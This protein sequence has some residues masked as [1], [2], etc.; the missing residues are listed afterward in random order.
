MVGY[1]AATDVVRLRCCDKRRWSVTLLLQTSLVGYAAAK[2]RLK[3]C[4][5]T[6]TTHVQYIYNTTK[7]L[8]TYMFAEAKHCTGY[9]ILVKLC[10]QAG[11]SVVS[12]NSLSRFAT[13]S[14][15]TNK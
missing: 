10:L 3:L 8:M 5:V 7:A 11:D 4:V 12:Y 9:M 6:I 15:K 2:V 14:L 13:L 1:D